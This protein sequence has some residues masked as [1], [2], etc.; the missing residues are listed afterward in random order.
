M[1][2]AGDDGLR[3]LD[4]IDLQ[5]VPRDRARRGAATEADDECGPWIRMQHGR[6]RADAMVDERSARRIIGLVIAGGGG[7]LEY[8]LHLRPEAVN[9]RLRVPGC[10]LYT[11]GTL[12]LAGIAAVV[13]SWLAVG[14]IRAPLIL[15]A[16]V[17]SGFYSGFIVLF[18]VWLKV[19]RDSS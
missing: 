1:I 2:G 17:L 15:G 4:D 6:Q 18:A 5:V 7:L 14:T 8:W 16:G 10:M 9:R 19:A 3:Q 11:A 13:V 12:A